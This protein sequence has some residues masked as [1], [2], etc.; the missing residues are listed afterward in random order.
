MGD[1]SL[2]EGCNC[3]LCHIIVL[4]VDDVEGSAAVDDGLNDLLRCFCV[5]VSGLLCNEVPAVVLSY[6]GVEGAGSA[7]LCSGTHRALDMYYVVLRKSLGSQPVNCGLT[8]LSHVGYDGSLVQT[9]VSV[10]GSVEQD[11]LD[12]L[13]LSVLEHGI[14]A[15]SASGGDEQVVHLRLNECLCRCDLLVVLKA[16]CKGSVVTVLLC[17]CSLHVLVVRCTIAGLVGVVVDYS[18]LDEVSACRTRARS[19]A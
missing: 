19:A 17:E 8:F 9:F 13:S 7:D 18:Y 12:S 3:A 4:G 15:G 1:V 2:V 16:V 14:P 11:N 6:L 10:D 5:P